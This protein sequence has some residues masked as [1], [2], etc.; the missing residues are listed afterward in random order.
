MN[1]EEGS[2]GVVSKE[3]RLFREK[4]IKIDKER[5]EKEEELERFFY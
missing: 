2:S 5:K 4:Q 3:V 1:D